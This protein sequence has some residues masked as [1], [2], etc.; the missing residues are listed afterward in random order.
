ML[1]VGLTGG[2]GAGKSTV[3]ELLVDRGAVLVDADAIAR[4][5]VEPG[6]PAYEALVRRFGSSVLTHDGRVDRPRLASI[7]FA[8]PGALADLNAITHPAIAGIMDQRRRAEMGTDHV[9]VFDVPLLT[10]AHRKI[11][12]LDVVIVVDCPADIALERLV[13]GRGMDPADARARMA[14]QPSRLDRVAGADLVVFNGSSYEALV[15]EVDRIWD[16]IESRRSAGAGP[17]RTG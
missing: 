15:G 2:I 7:V 5:V 6:G 1:A 14:A 17:S 12:G 9:V 16:A 11:L 13:A 4:E 3:A 8:D 10:P